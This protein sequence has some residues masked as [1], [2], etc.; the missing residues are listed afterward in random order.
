MTYVIAE[1]GI[2]HNGDMGLARHLIEQ[3]S[4]AGCNAVKFQKREVE[5]VYSKE[6][7]D[8]DR[9]SPWGTTNREQKEGLELSIEQHKELEEFTRSLGMDYII[10]CWDLTSLRE[11]EEHLNV[12]YHKI[13]SAMA[14]DEAFIT[15][16]NDTGKKVIL[17]VGMCTEEDI[18]NAVSH[19]DNLEYILCCTST[20]PTKREEVNL[21]HITTTKSAYPKYKVGF[22]NHYNGKDACVGA[23]ALGAECVEFHI[24]KDRAMYGSDQ[25]ASIQDANVLVSGIRNM[26]IMLGDG[27]KVFYET[28][29]PIAD[30]LR[31]VHSWS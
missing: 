25:A 8:K 28:E 22:S 10:S 18:K 9:E 31:K 29:K 5:E 1:V 11:V 14:C 4:E 13:A 30:K 15:A 2:N 27:E 7:L 20:Y 12:D 6:E 17:S 19:I 21:L 24:T 23:T 26:E 16:L 3:A